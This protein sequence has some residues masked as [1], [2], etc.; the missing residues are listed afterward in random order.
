VRYKFIKT[1]NK[2]RECPQA[3]LPEVLIVGRTNAGKSSLINSF[4]NQKIAYVS[5]APGRTVLLNFYEAGLYRIVDSPGYGFSIGGQTNDK[6][7]DDYLNLRSTLV[8]VLLIMDIRRK[9]T[10]QEQ[11]VADMLATRETPWAIV[12]T[13]IDKLNRR[14]LE[15][16]VRGLKKVTPLVFPVSSLK[17]TGVKELQKFVF[18]K[19]V[20]ARNNKKEQIE[21]LEDKAE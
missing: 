5:S 13:K 12:P 15:G 8:G 21:P 4:A 20:Q 7:V 17:K 16:F 18:E 6:V 14:D 9:W 2:Y 10:D 11:A 1:V 19:W 3:N